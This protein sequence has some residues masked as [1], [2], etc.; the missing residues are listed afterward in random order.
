MERNGQQK[1]IVLHVD[2]L[3]LGT[4]SEKWEKGSCRPMHAENVDGEAPFEVIPGLR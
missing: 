1:S 3:L 4:F 2:D